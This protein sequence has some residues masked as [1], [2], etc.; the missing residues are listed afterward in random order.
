MTDTDPDTSADE[1]VYH[2]FV[3]SEESAVAVTALRLLIS[4][5]AHEPGIRALARDVIERLTSE[6]PA[7]EAVLTVTLSPPAMKI[8]HTAVK[9]LLD[10]LQR[11]QQ[12]ER[13]IL[14]QILEKLPDEHAIR[15][16]E[17]EPGPAPRP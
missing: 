1:L 9:L 4:D 12:Q 6:R 11:G 7:E 10:D 15:A 13:R 5:E 2:L 8:T 3:N 14:R 17:L 16:I